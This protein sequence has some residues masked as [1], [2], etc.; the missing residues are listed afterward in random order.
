ME[1]LQASAREDFDWILRRAHCV[2]TPYARALKAVDREGAIRGMVAFDNW[3]ENAVQVH[4]AVDA[5]IVW[6]RLLPAAFRFAF[7]HAGKGLMVGITPASNARSLN[8][9]W[10]TGFR[11]AYRIRDG[12]AAGEDMVISEMRREECRYL[13]REVAHGR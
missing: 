5:P 9:Q 1:V 3:T 8:F 11:P 4:M 6:R 7:E 10:K 12:W 2:L 13:N